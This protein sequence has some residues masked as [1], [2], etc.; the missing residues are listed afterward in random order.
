[1]RMRKLM[2]AGGVVLGSLAVGA[3]ATPGVA[4]AGPYTTPP[5]N[6]TIQ[7]GSPSGPTDP[8]SLP[9]TVSPTTKSSVSSLPFT[10]ADVEEVAG[11]GVAAVVVGTVLTRR[12]RAQA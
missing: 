9:F 8:N 10:G 1:M 11:L 6:Q 4:A 5:S 7:G 2:A 12:R 3:L